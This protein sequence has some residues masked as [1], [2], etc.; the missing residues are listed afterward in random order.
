V[1][2]ASVATHE[3]VHSWPRKRKAAAIAALF[4]GSLVR[5]TSDFELALD[6]GLPPR[7]RP[8]SGPLPPTTPARERGLEEPSRFLLIPVL[9][10]SRLERYGESM[11]PP[12]WQRNRG[13]SGG[14][15]RSATCFAGGECPFEGW[16]PDSG[17][18]SCWARLSPGQPQTA[19]ESQGPPPGGGTAVSPRPLLCKRYYSPAI[20]ALVR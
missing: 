11:A 14:R 2:R 6:P 7:S 1:T 15:R 10:A 13:S 19:P 17:A 8:A 5:T 16:W 4:P 20:V 12:A 9:P 3:S 18:Q